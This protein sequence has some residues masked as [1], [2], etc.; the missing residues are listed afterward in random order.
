MSISSVSF[1]Y[2]PCS[3][4]SKEK[5]IRKL[6]EKIKAL[7]NLKNSTSFN[8]FLKKGICVM[9]RNECFFRKYHLKTTSRKIDDIVI[10]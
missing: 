2:S 3:K 8:F 10:H 9:T 7:N 5:K 4:N 1:I 6:H